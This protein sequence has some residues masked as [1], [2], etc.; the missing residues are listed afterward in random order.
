MRARYGCVCFAV[1]KK[2]LAHL[3]DR[4]EG[5]QKRALVNHL[6][7][8][9]ELRA[10]R[11]A[12][13]ARRTPVSQPGQKKLHRQIFDAQ[14]Q[15]FLP[16]KLL[17]GEEASSTADQSANQAYDNIGIALRFFETVLGRNSVDGRGMRIDATVHYGFGFAN[18]L[19]TGEQMIVGDGDGHHVS[20]LAGSLG[21]IAHELSHGVSQHLIRGGLGVVQMAGQPPSLKGEAGALNESFSDVCASMVKQW[22]LGQSVDAADWL[23]GE[24][25]LAPHAGRAIRSLKDP[26]NKHE[27]WAS[28]DQIRDFR[29]FKA[30]DD[31]HK[32]SGVANFAF[33]SA[34]VEL[35]GKSWETLGPV[36]FQG[37]DRLRSRATFLDAAHATVEVAANVHGRNSRAH[38][39]VK[40]AWQR[41]NVMN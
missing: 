10:R 35:G 3:A 19:W 11:A 40:A 34:A 1:P 12:T 5:D 31:P 25:V 30:T 32:G 36:W 16:G 14:G 20:N 39:A 21:I 7:H 37:F 8:S 6:H 26:G 29:R 41:V 28:D 18:A 24:D 27:T 23:L 13:S 15:T 4:S 17:R 2:L 38:R 33:Y 22:H 9:T